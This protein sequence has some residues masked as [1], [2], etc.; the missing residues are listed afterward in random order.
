[1]AG[2]PVRIQ[3]RAQRPA[4]V[5]VLCGLLAVFVYLPTLRYELVWD[6]Q[7]LI[8]RSRSSLSAAFVHSFWYGGGAGLLGQDPYYR[9]L[10]NFSLGLDELVAG[11]R[12]WY[13]HLVNLLLHAAAVALAGVVV[14]LLFGSRWLLLVAGVVCAIHPLAADS[15]AYVSGRTDLLAAIGLLVALLGL[16]RLEKRHDWSAIAMVWTGFAVGMLSKETGV[17]FAPLAAIWL[18]ALGPRRRERKDWVALSGLVALLGVY[19]ALRYAV[20]R[21]PV[22]MS[23]G[24]NLGAWLILSLNNFGRLLVASVWPWLQGVFAGNEVALTRPT[25]YAGASV[26]YLA[27]PLALRRWSNS[28]AAWLAWLWGLAMLLPFAGLAGFGPV[29]RLLYVPGIGLVILTL[30]L[31]REMTRGHRRRRIGAVAAALGYCVLL[32]LFLL[33]RR[34]NVWRDGYTLFRQMTTE[35]PDYPAAHFNYAFEL[36]KRGDTDGAIS[37]Y[38]KT[39]ALDPSMAL[40]YSNLGALLQSRGEVV[41]AESL[42]LKTIALRPNY[43]LAWN[44]LGAVRYRRGDAGGAARAFRQAIELKPDDAGAVYNL[45][46][47]YQ[48][49]GMAD[50]AA[51]MFERAFRLEPGNPQ[52]RASYEQTHVGQP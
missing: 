42:Y 27:A 33:P 32:T 23:V 48:Q 28:R 8:V 46:R 39:V 34:M 36:R 25:W 24:F 49:A 18:A 38:R 26:A 5:V 29:G 22:G 41:E 19:L 50:S 4:L 1:V 9:P 2:A 10:V 31:G 51:L 14:W 40:A 35:S 11:H 3:Q 6:D 30:C 15:V 20:L 7:D 44:N 13:F 47:L 37:Q 12:A 52:I 16:L 45:G 17:M 43:A 21:S